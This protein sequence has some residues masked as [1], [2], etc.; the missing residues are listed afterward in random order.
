MRSRQIFF[1]KM[2]T[3][4]GKKNP[5]ISQQYANKQCRSRVP[6]F[7]LLVVILLHTLYINK[8]DVPGDDNEWI[9]VIQRR[10]FRFSTVVLEIANLPSGSLS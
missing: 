4:P 9:Q 10:Q 1:D 2:T 8:L 6:G 7:W 3:Q 5:K